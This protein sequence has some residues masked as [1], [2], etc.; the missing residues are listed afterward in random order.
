MSTLALQRCLNHPAR[1]AAARCVECAQ[2]Y[3]R[4]CVSEHEG[5]LLCAAC[6]RKLAKQGFFRAGWGRRLLQ[7]GQV[8]VA[9]IFLWLCFFAL[10]KVLLAIPASFHDAE[11]WRGKTEL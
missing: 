10:G 11:V 3:C 9:F 6:L 7:A 8:C 5:R 4:E 2:P 1:E